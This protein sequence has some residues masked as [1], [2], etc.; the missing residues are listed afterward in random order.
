M[1]EANDVRRELSQRLN[2]LTIYI[3]IGLFLF[4]ALAIVIDQRVHEDSEEAKGLQIERRSA[5][6][7]AE[8]ARQTLNRL[9]TG[10]IRALGVAAALQGK[11]KPGSRKPEPAT[12]GKEPAEA[13]PTEEKGRT[14]PGSDDYTAFEEALVDSTVLVDLP[15]TV[16]EERFKDAR[17]RLT[18][19]SENTKGGYD[20]P[21]KLFQ[22]FVRHAYAYLQAYTRVVAADKALND[23][24]HAR[25]T[26]PTPFGEFQ[27]KPKVALVSIALMASI[28][29]VLLTLE[30]RHILLL[31]VLARG[32]ETV[33]APVWLYSDDTDQRRILGWS[34][35]NDRG[36]FLSAVLVHGLW[37]LLTMWLAAEC[38]RTEVAGEALFLPP[39]PMSAAIL[40]GAS[41]AVATFVYQF[42]PAR[43]SKTVDDVQVAV[44][45]VA[46]TTL[47]RRAAAGAL[48]LGVGGLVA[49][50]IQK[51]F[52]GV[53]R[54]KGPYLAVAQM[55][56][57]RVP[58][59]SQQRLLQ[60]ARFRRPQDGRRPTVHDEVLCASHLPQKRQIAA[61]GNWIHPGREVAVIYAIARDLA[62]STLAL[63]G[64]RREASIADRREFERQVQ[65]LENLLEETAALQPWSHHVHDLLIRLYGRRQGYA[66]IAMLLQTSLGRLELALGKRQAPAMQ[67]SLL[68]AKA[69]MEKR[70]A[71]AKRRE[72]SRILRAV[73]VSGE[74]AARDRRA[75]SVGSIPRAARPTSPS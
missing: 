32:T 3:A 21:K 29:Y 70:A 41:A 51:A 34:A 30:T 13:K 64:A 9:N 24:K 45:R 75:T 16:R 44:Q 6:R 11:P 19:L 28:C 43:V 66:E 72:N 15:E 1:A 31:A 36:R 35:K 17:Q 46:A 22:G 71:T 59:P 7:Q 74:T 57:A 14:I 48:L 54:R 18:L 23:A 69:E 55:I 12:P 56:Q 25:Q 50:R 4:A 42:F 27:V 67:R 8:S 60:N 26:V 68:K 33:L 62:A 37:L 49:W 47:T 58:G 20:Q 2:K 63:P 40:G 53:E 39:V 73:S 38:F 61:A 52:R 5:E 65:S 10:F